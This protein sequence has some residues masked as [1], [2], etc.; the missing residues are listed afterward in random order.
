MYIH[1]WIERYSELLEQVGIRAENSTCN[2]TLRLSQLPGLNLHVHVDLKAYI[3]CMCNVMCLHL[4]III[5]NYI[6]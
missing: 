3:Q 2:T 6:L 4:I 5:I 1:I